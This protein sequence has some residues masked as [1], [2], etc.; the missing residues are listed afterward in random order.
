MPIVLTA[1]RTVE[2]K[3]LLTRED[4]FAPVGP[5]FEL[6]LG[7][8]QPGFLMAF[9]ELGGGRHLPVDEMGRSLE[10]ALHRT[11]AHM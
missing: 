8:Y 2:R 4:N 5:F 10:H 9:R 3:S 7:P 1:I 11:R 6:F